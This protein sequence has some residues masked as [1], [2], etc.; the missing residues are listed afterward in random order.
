MK[1]IIVFTLLLI[2]SAPSF[3]QPTMTTTPDVK[4]G[5]QKKSENQKTAA[6]T[7]F[8]GGT[9]VLA[10]TGLANAGVDFA[11]PRKRTFPGAE[12]SIGAAMMAGSIPFFIAAS[13]N[14]KKARDISASFKMENRLLVQQQSF[15]KCSYPALSLK[16]SL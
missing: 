10:I 12:V 15:I 13:K 4:T 9:V 16:I 5:Y 11:N 2:A 6:W 1:K 7:L 8:I 14:K 3:S